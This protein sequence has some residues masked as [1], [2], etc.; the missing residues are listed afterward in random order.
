[1]SDA[2]WFQGDAVDHA[3]VIEIEGEAYDRG[4]QYGAAVASEVFQ[5]AEAYLRLVERQAGLGRE[6]AL[7]AA[8][9]FGPPIEAYAPDLFV[10]MRGI[11]D[12]AG[13][14]LNKVLLINART[15]LLSSKG[16]CTALAAAPEVTQRGQVLLGQNWDWYTAIK[17]DP[18]LLSIRQP[19]RPEILTLVEPGQLAKIGINSAG[20]GICLNYLE[21]T[22]RG[23]GLPVHVILRQ[24]LGCSHLGAAIRM[25]YSAPR[26]AS[27]NI[28]IGHAAGEILDVE[29]TPTRGDFVYGDGGWLVHAN[30][31]E[32]MRL[33]SGDVGIATSMSSL[34][35]AARARRLLSTTCGSISVDTFQN[36]LRDH[37]H[38]PYAICRHADSSE[39]PLDQTATRASAIMDLAARKMH[40][41]I[42]NPCQ[43]EYAAYSVTEDGT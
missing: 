14:T 11:A 28:L 31:F 43:N 6:A 39:N 10:E 1:M 22:D 34:A 16:E 36:I 38:G 23:Q 26:A 32:S 20:L 15:E 5:S 17:S 29:F 30:H 7:E 18:V 21:H 40:L 25:T 13:C 41:A 27:A 9:A 35:R 12:G 19:G 33:R 8:A 3:Q 24:M 42:A 4:R 2:L 37:A